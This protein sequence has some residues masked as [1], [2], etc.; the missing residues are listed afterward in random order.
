MKIYA[1]GG[2]IRDELL[3][4]PV[5]DRD[6]VVVG[7]TPETMLALGYK[8]VGRDFPVF[9]HPVTHEEYALARTERK[10]GPGYTGFA[11][12]ASPDVTLEQDL[13]RRDLTINAIARDDAGRL[14][15]PFGGIPDLQAR[16]LRHVSAAFAEDPV[17]ILRVARF[18]ARFQHRFGFTVAPE[19]LQ[20]MQR[21][22]EAGEVDALVAERVWTELSRGLCEPDPSVLFRVLE[23]CHALPRLLPE[24]VP[25]WTR[26][27]A[28]AARSV[29]C[30]AARAAPLAVRFAAWI[31][32]LVVP[33]GA[34]GHTLISTLGTRLRLPHAVQDLTSL[35]CRLHAALHTRF[36]AGPEELLALLEAGDGLRRPQRLQDLLAV[37]ACSESAQDT[38]L[39]ASGDPLLR[40]QAA[41]A[42]VDT[43]A[44]AR[45]ASSPSAIAASIRAA[46]LAAIGQAF[47]RGA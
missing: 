1:V 45:D 15:D 11:I 21:M 29:D 2:A 38:P 9:L 36:A 39:P 12:H 14:I 17:R 47:S 18:A 10:T 19:T 24:L 6:W 46:R 16:Q 31:V 27:G 26:H 37:M 20:L 3:G 42:T 32:P 44:L 33:S 8:P 28:A 13:A 40:A 5:Q 22:V 23:E 30:A 41:A 4:L 35:A 25:Y 7:A 34:G 43:A